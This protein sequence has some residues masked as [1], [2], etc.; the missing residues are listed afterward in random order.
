M[1]SEDALS[2]LFERAVRDLDPPVNAIVA[3]AERRGRRLRKRRR[4]WLAL[5]GG[6]AAALTATAVVAAMSLAQPQGTSLVSAGSAGNDTS[7]SPTGTGQVTA[8][9]SPS[10]TVTA[11]ATPSSSVTA[12]ATPS[13]TASSNPFNGAMPTLAKG[14]Q[15]PVAEMIAALRHLLPA[16]SNLGY[17][18]PYST[19]PGTL[20]IDYNDGNGAADIQIS[21]APT[22]TF[23][24]LS[25]PTP[26]WKD[27]GPRPPGALP[28]SCA[29]RTLP[30]GSIERDAVY[31]A[32]AYG[33]YAYSVYVNR[34][35]GV[36]VDVE[37]GN[38]ILH[39]LPQVDRARPPGSMSQW[40][41]LAENPVWQLKKGWHLGS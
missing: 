41:A 3:A 25:C 38:G 2:D 9:A 20:E 14:Y 34:P 24:P 26:L 32:D 15:M 5:G 12:T 8:T 10:T 23:A 22:A 16:G 39:A 21:I 6:S 40:A 18:N 1:I 29:M 7:A 11:T 19:E 4:A 33:F 36:T 27:E 31:Y 17:V 35:D 28:I 37:V 13:T 30:D